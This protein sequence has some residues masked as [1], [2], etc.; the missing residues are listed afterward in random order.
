MSRPDP[1][2][3]QRPLLFPDPVIEHHMA[4]VDRAAIRERLKLTAEERLAALQRE[5]DARI[6]Q[7]TPGAHEES[8]PW[9]TKKSAINMGSDPSWFAEAKAIPLLVPDPVIEA[10]LEDVD[11]GLIR[12]ALRLS[13]SDRFEAFRRLVRGAHAL[14]RA[15]AK[16][17]NESRD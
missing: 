11:R 2:P 7:P 8:P 13:V 4:R 9:P 16:E 10:Y 17:D 12:Q 15:C 6:A 5:V 14:A 3:A 1:D